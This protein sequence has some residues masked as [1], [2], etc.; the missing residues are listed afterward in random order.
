MAA[1]ESRLECALRKIAEAPIQFSPRDRCFT[2]DGR[3]KRGLTKIIEE[4]MPIPRGDLETPAATVTA[5]ALGRR[6]T[7]SR[8]DAPN[9]VTKRARRSKN[10]PEPSPVVW[11]NG[12]ETA[13]FIKQAVASCRDAVERCELEGDD[14][15]NAN[16]SFNVRHGR[17]VDE[18]I[19]L[20]VVHGHKVFQSR[21]YGAMKGGLDPCT[22][23]LFD[24]L[25]AKKQRIVASQAP[26]YSATMDCATAFDVITQ[27]ESLYEIKSTTVVGQQAIERSDKN[28]E[29][30]RSRVQNTALRGTPCSQY[31]AGQVQ[32]HV[33]AEM[34][35]E[36]TDGWQPVD[37]AVL[38]V[39]PSVV[40]IYA[41]NP[42][43]QSRATR[44]SRAIAQ[45]TGQHKR[46]KRTKRHQ[47]KVG[48]DAGTRTDGERTGQVA[49]H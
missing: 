22:A 49:A 36:T 42:W 17:L 47:K 8:S 37:A 46:N 4:V 11:R 6:A 34:I 25:R 24:F 30:P 3:R 16:K 12:P 20:R 21:E 13:H 19:K 9:P 7:D 31:S 32:L 27:D 14:E 18:Q 43:F 38:R 33:T 15:P 1:P 29:T 5:A 40:R 26:L 28:Y 48:R 10:D 2:L 45:R 35:K 39:S 44:F 41:L 23:T